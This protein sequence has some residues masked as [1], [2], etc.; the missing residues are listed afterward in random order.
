VRAGQGKARKRAVV[1]RSS[2]PTQRGMARRTSVWET[3]LGVVGVRCR[4][5]LLGVAPETIACHALEL[6]SHVTGR[7]FDLGVRSLQGEA[8][9]AGVI[10]AGVLPLVHAVAL[11]AACRYSG[12]SV[13]DA[14]GRLVVVEVTAYAL[15]TQPREDSRGRRAVTGLAFDCRVRPH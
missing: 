10:K 4:V 2:L 9:K 15:R 1:E 13:V 6:S 3:C 12:C 7:A 14:L 8:R 5:E 11:P